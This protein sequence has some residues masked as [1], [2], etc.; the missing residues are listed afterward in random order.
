MRAVL[1]QS[2]TLDGWLKGDPEDRTRGPNFPEKRVRRSGDLGDAGR[3]VRSLPE[4]VVPGLTTA[5]GR[6]LQRLGSGDQTRWCL[7]AHPGSGMTQPA[8]AASHKV[9][10][11]LPFVNRQLCQHCMETK[12]KGAISL[13]SAA[14]KEGLHPVTRP[15]PIAAMPSQHAPHAAH[16]LASLD[17]PS[18][19]HWSSSGEPLVIPEDGHGH[20]QALR[21]HARR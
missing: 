4:T 13:A 3:S 5:G 21:R 14:S 6:P 2:H 8:G 20:P 11:T 9:S 1:P 7:A 12:I 18:A 17:D 15:S 16:V 19:V 10:P